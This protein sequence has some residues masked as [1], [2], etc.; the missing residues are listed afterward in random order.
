[1]TTSTTG[2]RPVA[3]V[4]GE[5]TGD[6]V[7]DLQRGYLEDES[8]A[9][10]TLAQLRRGA[11][12]VPADVPELWGVTGTEAL[13]TE[14]EIPEW[15]QERV[16]AAHFLAVTLYASHQQSHLRE[17]MHRRR[18]DAEFGA[19][20]RRL[21]PRDAIDEAIR[22]K[23]VRIGTSDTLDVLADR[24]RDLISLLRRD[25]IPLDYAL[26]AGQLYQAQFPDGMRAVRQRWGRSFH[27]YRPPNS[28]KPEKPDQPEKDV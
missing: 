7:A 22:R 8:A 14:D 23:F 21:M 6:Y 13:F 4:I 5:I 18:R 3:E 15:E 17:R 10:A 2:R 12:K 16:E 24:L 1:M 20:I 26:L 28:D 19:A 11:G 25:S 27:A 9:V